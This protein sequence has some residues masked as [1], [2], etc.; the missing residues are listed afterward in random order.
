MFTH[1]LQVLQ[2]LVDQLKANTYLEIG[3]D[4]GNNF[5]N[6]QA[7]TKVGVDPSPAIRL[8]ERWKFRQQKAPNTRII[9]KTS[10]EFFK[11]YSAYLGNQLIDV[12]F[13]DGLHTYAQALRDVENCLDH[14]SARGVIVMHDCLPPHAMAATPAS[15][16]KKLHKMPG[17]DGLWCGDVW[18]AVLHLRATRS[19]IDMFVL[20]C[21]FGLGVIS[22]GHQTCLDLSVDTIQSLNFSDYQTNQAAW[23]NVCSPDTLAQWLSTSKILLNT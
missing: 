4:N 17:F 18:K 23:A 20:N 19:D 15:E 3:V 7:P 5:Y 1:R 12:A 16:I 22:K 8:R 6:L 14:L 2:Y 10:D 9:K 11:N 13:V 21:D